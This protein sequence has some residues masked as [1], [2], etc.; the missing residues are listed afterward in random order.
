MP[1]RTSIFSMILFVGALAAPL[2]AQA[3]I[4]SPPPELD[5]VKWY[6]SPPMTLAELKGK[7]VFVDVFRTWCG[8]CQGL[9]PSVSAL[10]EKKEAEGLFVIGVTDEEPRLVDQFIKKF[11][12]TYPIVIL[13][14]KD[15]EAALGVTFFPTGGI[16]EPSG[17]LAFAAHASEAEAKVES[18]LS[19]SKP[20]KSIPEKLAPVLASMRVNNLTKAYADVK[21]V[22]G[23]DAKWI[24]RMVK[25]IESEAEATLGAA[26]ASADGGLLYEAVQKVTPVAKSSPPFPVT[27]D[28]VAFLKSLE[29]TPKYKLELSGGEK[30]EKARELENSQEYSKAVAAYGEIVKSAAGTKISDAARKQADSLI[31][32]GMPGYK[33]ECPACQKDHKACEKHKENMKV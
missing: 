5:A 28:A 2:S 25:Y 30:F 4:G 23:L 11:K 31:N 13:K 7:T 17:N 1:M 16:I 18:Y 32:K 29:T 8:P 22:A 15:F 9:V 14:N 10:F 26:K 3:K 6:N 19:K 12:P 20:G 27:K 33:G 24:E 21:K